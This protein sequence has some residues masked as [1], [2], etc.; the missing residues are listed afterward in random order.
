MCTRIACTIGVSLCAAGGH[1]RVLELGRLSC[2]S[3]LRIAHVHAARSTA[4]ELTA[5]LRNRCVQMR[6]LMKYLYYDML[7]HYASWLHYDEE[8]AKGRDVTSRS[9]TLLLVEHLAANED[10]R[11]DA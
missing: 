2:A 1:L 5:W 9:L 8:L 7:L 4:A 10:T 3:D 6:R 11:C